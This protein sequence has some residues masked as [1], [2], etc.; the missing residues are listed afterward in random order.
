MVAI[1]VS[2]GLQK[3]VKK[4]KKTRPYVKLIKTLYD[5]GGISETQS[6]QIM[7][8]KWIAN[9]QGDLWPK[10]GRLKDVK[11]ASPES[12]AEYDRMIHENEV[13]GGRKGGKN[14]KGVLKG[15]PKPGAGRRGNKSKPCIPH[16]Q[17]KALL[18]SIKTKRQ[19]E[20][21]SAV[22]KDIPLN[23]V[24]H[25][26]PRVL[27]TLLFNMKSLADDPHKILTTSSAIK[28]ARKE[29]YDVVRIREAL[30]ACFIQGKSYAFLLTTMLLITVASAFKLRAHEIESATP[31]DG[32]LLATGEAPIPFKAAFV[33]KPKAA[34]NRNIVLR[35]LLAEIPLLMK[36]HQRQV[37]IYR[38]IETHLDKVPSCPGHRAYKKNVIYVQMSWQD[39]KKYE[40]WLKDQIARTHLR[41]LHES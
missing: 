39:L 13:A 29:G 37:P 3:K 16:A 22:P 41:S 26:R 30:L 28:F 21:I 14:S 24:P 6:L 10:R 12:V 5:T 34:K 7:R 11:I 33:P 27:K 2:G 32:I 20:S 38:L 35:A 8:A 17:D 23:D 40:I 4:A 1:R 9:N 15:V 36:A 19:L 18:E 31:I 25:H